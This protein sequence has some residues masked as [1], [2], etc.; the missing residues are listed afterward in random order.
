MERD[1]TVKGI[2]FTLL[3]EMVEQEAGLAAWDACISQI[4]SA[5]DGVY[6][7]PSVYPDEELLAIIGALSESLDVPVRDLVRAFGVYMLPRLLDVYRDKTV[8]DGG[9]KVFLMSVDGVIHE[10]VKKLWPDAQLPRFRHDDTGPTSLT[11][12]YTSERR[13]CALAEGLIDGA[14]KA[15]AT[16]VQIGHVTCMH[17]GADCC[18]FKLIFADG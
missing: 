5:S 8:V 6:I 11:L 10:E 12:Y 13:L 15:F 16:D 14:G 18:T 2:V 3:Q 1:R 17:D 4:D 7:A 9:L